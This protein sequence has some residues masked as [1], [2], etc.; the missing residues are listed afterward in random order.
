MNLGATADSAAPM[1]H[2]GHGAKP[3]GGRRRLP[4]AGEVRVKAAFFAKG[5]RV[6]QAAAFGPQLDDAA[7]NTYF[8]SLKLP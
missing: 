8:T 2:Q 5:T 1:A 4:S 3:A 7:P 6:F